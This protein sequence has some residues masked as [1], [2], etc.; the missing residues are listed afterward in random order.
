MGVSVG[1]SARAFSNAAK[2]RVASPFLTIDPA[3]GKEGEDPGRT[4]HLFVDREGQFGNRVQWVDPISLL[5]PGSVTLALYVAGVV[6]APDD[7]CRLAGNQSPK[8][9]FTIYERFRE[10]CDSRS[11]NF[12]SRTSSS[13]ASRMRPAPLKRW[14]LAV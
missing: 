1:F 13:S 7:G 6:F 2:A 5:F 3:Q 10:D 12:D 9:L 4:G 14:S 11:L 8:G